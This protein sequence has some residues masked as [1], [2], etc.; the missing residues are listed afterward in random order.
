MDSNDT[1]PG[2]GGMDQGNLGRGQNQRQPLTGGRHH[3]RREQKI[4]EPQYQICLPLLRNH[5]PGNTGGQCNLR[6]LQRA[7]RAGIKKE[8][9]RPLRLPLNG[10]IWAMRPIAGGGHFF[11][12]PHFL[13]HK[14]RRGAKMSCQAPTQ[15]PYQSQARWRAI[16]PSPLKTEKARKA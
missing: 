15:P 16:L 3:Q 4:Q 13:I 1:G 2:D 10:S 12:F 11:A 9:G 8:S 5:H 14:G 7:F 6:G